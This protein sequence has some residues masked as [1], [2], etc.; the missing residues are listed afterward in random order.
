MALNLTAILILIPAIITTRLDFLRPI[1]LVL[2]L[3]FIVDTFVNF[4]TGYEVYSRKEVVM[5]KKAIRRFL[6]NLHQRF[7]D[8]SGFIYFQKVHSWLLFL[9]FILLSAY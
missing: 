1:K 4:N 6:Y 9:G 3:L 5:S 7:T 2:D 8:S